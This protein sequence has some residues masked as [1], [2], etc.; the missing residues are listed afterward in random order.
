MFDL[1]ELT[2][3]IL[4]RFTLQRALGIHPHYIPYP[5]GDLPRS[6]RFDLHYIILLP[7]YCHPATQKKIFSINYASVDDNLS[8]KLL[9]ASPAFSC[10]MQID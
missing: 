5:L 6:E 4:Q 7:A 8:V 1:G 3:A 10:F 9:L 2:V